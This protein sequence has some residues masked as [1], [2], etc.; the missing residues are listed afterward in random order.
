ME[1]RTDKHWPTRCAASATLGTST[2][3][4]RP[5]AMW[6]KLATHVDVTVAAKR[7][8]I[9]F[10]KRKGDPNVATDYHPVAFVRRWRGL[11]RLFALGNRRRN[12]DY[13]DGHTYRCAGFLVQR[14][15]TV[16]TA[17]RRSQSYSQE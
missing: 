2:S 1:I 14:N 7:R 17:Q 3:N 9:K 5:S 6:S 8:L 15:A 12:G 4:S 16:K 11:L 13:W 10:C